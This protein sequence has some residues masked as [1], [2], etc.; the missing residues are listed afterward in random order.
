M[1]QSDWYAKLLEWSRKDS[2][3]GR[4]SFAL[5]VVLAEHLEEHD[6]AEHS[7]QATG[8]RRCP[9]CKALLEEQSVYCDTC[10]TDTPRA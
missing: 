7:V 3:L 8:L 4:L 9:E 6:A 2:R 10:G 5:M 1:N